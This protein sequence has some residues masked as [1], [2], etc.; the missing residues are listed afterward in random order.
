[1]DSPV[2][3]EANPSKR[4][5]LA[6]IGAAAGALALL[7]AGGWFAYDRLLAG[8]EIAAA[9]PATPG[10]APLDAVYTQLPDIVTGLPR[11][12]NVARLGLVLETR[13][14]SGAPAEPQVLR[15]TEEVRRWVAAQE[16]T[17]L[18]GPAALWTVR[19]RSLAIARQLYP[20]LGVRDVLIR[21]LLIQ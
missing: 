21:V 9:H 7:G 13:R 17:A 3:S 2:S 15:I 8:E 20:E 5:R 1:M 16:P 14:E 11:A 12:G 10:R 6:I 18:E 4:R 19:A